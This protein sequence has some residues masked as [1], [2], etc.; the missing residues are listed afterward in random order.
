MKWKPDWSD[1]ADNLLIGLMVVAVAAA[2][3]LTFGCVWKAETTSRTIIM[4]D[5]NQSYAC[6]ISD[7]SPTPYDCKPIEDAEE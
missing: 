5:G 3:I 7:M 6:E 1:I 4:R 2:F